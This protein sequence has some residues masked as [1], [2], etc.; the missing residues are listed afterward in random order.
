MENQNCMACVLLDLSAAFDT[1]DHNLLLRILHNQYGIS[2]QALHWYDTYLRPREFKVSIHDKYSKPRS[3]N[4]SVPQGSA[5][6]ANIFTA[7]CASIVEV[8]PT[9]LSLQGF[10]D[11]HSI[12][13]LFKPTREEEQQAVESLETTMNSIKVWMSS[14]RLKLNTDKTE[15][16]IFGSQYQLKKTRSELFKAGEDTVNIC[17][18]VRC[19]GAFL[20]KNLNMKDHIKQ[21]S[22]IAMGNLM[23]IRN[24]RH[25]LT[26]EAC[27]TLVV[28]LVISHLDYCNSILIN[29]PECNLLPF[30]RIQ[31]MSAKLILGKS[32]YSSSKEAL[33]EL[34][35]LPIR[36]RISYKLLTIMHKITHG[37][38]PKYLSNLLT[39]RPV[40]TRLR[41]QTQVFVYI[42][43]RVKLKTF[44]FRSFSVQGPYL[45]NLLPETMRKD[46]NFE[47]FKKT[48]KSWLLNN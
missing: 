11:D 35:W 26:R 47:H 34:N 46:S 1:V 18:T 27:E 6:G 40:G 25:F 21:K 22:K 17:Q 24:I 31:N 33:R 4:F 28:G 45:W 7:Y 32:K 2:D 10:A 12:Y 30:I 43:P 5:S 19:L 39:L 42:V 38:A 3:L 44:A 8:I 36:S 20:D 48:V 23:K 15:F 29:L 9:G 14:M 41:S 16:I 13:K 37:T